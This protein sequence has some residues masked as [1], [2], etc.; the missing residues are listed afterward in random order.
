MDYKALLTSKKAKT[1]YWTT[2]NSM[3]VLVLGMINANEITIGDAVIAS[4]VIAGL[5]FATK[6]INQEYLTK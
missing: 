1:F 5:N 4:I 3:I 2:L 6:Y